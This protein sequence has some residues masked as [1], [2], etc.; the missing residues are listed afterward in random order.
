M[1][2]SQNKN[3]IQNHKE[4]N[5]SVWLT[6]WFSPIFR[7][8]DTISVFNLLFF[9]F[10][11]FFPT[12]IKAHNLLLRQKCVCHPPASDTFLFTNHH[13]ST[14]RNNFVSIPSF[15]LE[16]SSRDSVLAHVLEICLSPT[17]E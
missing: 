8:E 11:E 10:V 5:F 9:Q 16:L 7:S 13:L 17:G 6:Q 3:C 15:Y 4:K 12:K 2:F 1:L 14:K